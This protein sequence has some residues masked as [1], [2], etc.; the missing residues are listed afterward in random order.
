M[1]KGLLSLFRRRREQHF[2]RLI[3]TQPRYR[4]GTGFF[5][6]NDVG[7]IHAVR[8]NLLSSNPSVERVGP[9]NLY[10]VLYTIE[11]PHKPI[12]LRLDPSATIRC[13][14]KP[15]KQSS[16]T[17]F[18]RFVLYR[19][20]LISNVNELFSITPAYHEYMN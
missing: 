19:A 7:D 14:A 9:A 8:S 4:C 13:D 3:H 1:V 16:H 15:Q 12:Y 2:V 18:V 10:S 17:R 5:L 6:A 20:N 11:N